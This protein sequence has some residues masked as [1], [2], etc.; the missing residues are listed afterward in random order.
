MQDDRPH[1]GKI[2]KDLREYRGMS[3]EALAREAY[4]NRSTLSQIELGNQDCPDDILLA[5]KTVLKIESLPL[6]D[7]ERKEFKEALFKWNEVIGERRPDDARELREN[8][9]IVKLL[10]HDKEL[11]IFFSLFECRYLLSINE[12]A[13]AKGILDVFEAEGFSDIQLYHYYFNLGTYY[14]R[15]RL[16]QEALD[17]YL[18]AYEMMSFGFEKSIS[19]YYNISVCYSRLGY[20]SQA[21]SFLEEACMIRSTNQSNFNEMYLFVELG[22]IYVNTGS[23]QRAK[24][25]FDKAHTI[26]LNNYKTTKNDR[27]KGDLGMVLLNHGFLFRMGQKWNR[28][29][30]CFDK[31]LAYLDIAD[32]NYIE[33]LYQK[34]RS[35]IEMGNTLS[36]AKIIADGAK[37]SKESEVYSKMFEALPLLI[38][39][40]DESAKKLEINILPYLL[41]NN[42]FY[43][44]LDY[45]I[46]LGDYYKTRGRG[47]KT[48][49][50]E[51]SEIAYNILR[52]MR[53]GG[54]I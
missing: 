38:T 27:T 53:K 7:M 48:R 41:E 14:V 16:T 32:T 21:I 31:A 3:Q 9:A 34:A 25:L 49:S 36:C 54:V 19:L 51:M 44:A 29:I 18:K 28:A 15:S 26:A 8:L 23:L 4:F 5:I 33:T 42:Y 1:I 11:N 47:F 45:A 2:I 22:S 50:L 30:E 35:L 20:V 52:L 6:S 40:N 13:E 24:Y 12:L 43:P 10:P 39:P 17:F 46:F 37:L